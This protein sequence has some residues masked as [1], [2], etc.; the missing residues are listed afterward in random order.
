MNSVILA[1]NKCPQTMNNILIVFIQSTQFL[2][3]F[4]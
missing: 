3:S 2:C 4:I 1:G